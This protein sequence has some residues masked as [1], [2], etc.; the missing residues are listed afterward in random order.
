MPTMRP[1]A[2]GLR[3]KRTHWAALRSPVK[4]PR[5]ATS[6]GSSSRRMARPTH[7][8]PEPAVAPVMAKY[9]SEPRRLAVK[10]LTNDFGEVGLRNRPRMGDFDRCDNVD[11]FADV[12]LAQPQSPQP[13]R[14]S[15]PHV[16]IVKAARRVAD[17]ECALDA[18]HGFGRRGSVE[19]DG[20]GR[21]DGVGVGVVEIEPLPH[22]LGYGVLEPDLGAKIRRQPGAVEHIGAGLD[23]ARIL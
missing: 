23:I 4:R 1:D 3:T 5:P 15:E 20:V 12:F 11:G 21:G 13:G 9:V 6:A 18:C 14:Q 8:I 10:S 16:E 2:T 22:A 19:A 7:F 17:A